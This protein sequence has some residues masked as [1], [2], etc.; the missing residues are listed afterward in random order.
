MLRL[1][2]SRRAVA[3]LTQRR[4]PVP[5]RSG[6]LRNG[7]GSGDVQQL[8]LQN[9]THLNS[10]PSVDGKYGAAFGVFVPCTSTLFGLIVFLRL[11]FVVGQAG[12]WCSLLVIFAAFVLCL[13]TCLSLCALISD[14]GD[15]PPSAEGASIANEP[16]VY[17][18]LRRSLL[19]TRPG[20]ELG[21]ALGA[22]FYLVFAANVAFCLMSFAA[23]LCDAAGLHSEEQVLPWNPP[24]TWLEV[25]VASVALLLVATICAKGVS[26]PP[27]FSLFTLLGVFATILVSLLC[28]LIPTSQPTPTGINGTTFAANGAPALGSF[29]RGSDSSLV[30]MFALVFPGFTG[31]L[32]GSNVSCELRTPSR[33]FARGALSSLALTLA[34]YCVITLLLAASIERDTLKSN[35]FIVAEVVSSTIKLPLAH[36]CVCFV[37]ATSAVSYLLAAPR[38][39]TAIAIDSAWP[40]IAPLALRSRSGE[41]LRALGATCVLVQLLLLTGGISLLAPLVSAILLLAFTLINLLCFLA[42]ASAPDFARSFRLSSRWSALAGFVLSLI[43]MLAAISSAPLVAALLLALLLPPLLWQHRTLA[44][45]L[46]TG[47]NQRGDDGVSTSANMGLETDAVEQRVERAAAYVHDALQGRYRG[48]HWAVRSHSRIR[49]QRLLRSLRIV[50]TVNLCVYMVILSFF[51]RPVWCYAE[52]SCEAITEMGS[53]SAGPLARMNLPVLSVGSSVAIESVCILLF[54]GEMA[55]KAYYMTSRSFFASPWHVLQ[56][57]LLVLNG[58]FVLVQAC[59]PVNLSHQTPPDSIPSHPSPSST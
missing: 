25:G 27:R 23:V 6:L 1:G 53:G 33:S 41:P 35:V 14:S 7:R 46:R 45:L 29:N 20:Q 31:V 11:G 32:A 16:G 10:P 52:S 59:Q 22:S 56:F 43:G 37:A 48:S 58:A 30:L 51:E 26:L 38:V 17:F 50:R 49:A 39:F 28:C 47:W 5:S 8:L 42:A 55:L 54:T 34:S 12:W 21:V 57:V 24:G 13:L 3:A 15:A 18:V 44:V 4:G 40:A 19:C 2:R 9:F 36:I